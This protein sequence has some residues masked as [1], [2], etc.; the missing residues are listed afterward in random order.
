MIIEFGNNTVEIP[1]GY[2]VDALYAP[3]IQLSLLSVNQIDSAGYMATFR[4][5]KC[6]ISLPSSP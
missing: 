4:S 5:S 6:S 1:Q 3:M 2:Q